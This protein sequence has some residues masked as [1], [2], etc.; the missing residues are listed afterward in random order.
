MTAFIIIAF[1][2]VLFVSIVWVWIALHKKNRQQR[3]PFAGKS[4]ISE[5]FSRERRKKSK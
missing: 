4:T 3:E 5:L 2:A 1:S